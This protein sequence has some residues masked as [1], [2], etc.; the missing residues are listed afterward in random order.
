MGLYLYRDS[1]SIQR[2][3]PKYI[4]FRVN[5]IGLGLTI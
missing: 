3:R 4:G 5:Y 2:F 1:G